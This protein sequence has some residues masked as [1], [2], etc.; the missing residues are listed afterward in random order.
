MMAMQITSILRGGKT[1]KDAF[2]EYHPG[3]VLIYLGFL[4]LFC[5]FCMQPV[6]LLISVFCGFLYALLLKGK[7]LLRMLGRFI[8]P[9]AV[10]V[11]LLNPLLNTQGQTA[12]F[13]LPWGTVVT[14]ESVLFGFAA[15]GLML[16]VMF[17]FLCYQAVMTSE[18][19][20]YL[21]GQRFPSV[22]LVLTVAMR[23][24]P[25]FLSRFRTVRQVH[26]CL[27]I[28]V[29]RGEKNHRIKN[30]VRIFST[31]VSWSLEHALET[32]DSMVG[33]GYGLEGRTSY[34]A[35]RFCLRD[36]ILLAVIVF[37]IGL[38]GVTGFLGH[39]FSFSYFPQVGV[40]AQNLWALVF[41]GVYFVFCLIP[42]IVRVKE[43]IRWKYYR[44][45]I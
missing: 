37:G 6:C 24:I 3:V 16:S 43:A 20:L 2:S 41:Y 12:L 36:K 45:K 34:A 14:A 10:L 32:A 4:I 17:W 1:V 33:R 18:K 31:T 27:G 25:V 39:V 5:M 11:F 13:D 15:A 40:I 19:F 35:Y 21:F 26:Q 30:A 38:L 8:L 44:C 28:E 42:V 29:D 7:S 22:S 9:L 23:F